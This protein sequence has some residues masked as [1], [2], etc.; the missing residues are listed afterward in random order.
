MIVDSRGMVLVRAA[1]RGGVFGQWK[2]LGSLLLRG[3]VRVAHKF[4]AE[5]ARSQ[6]LS[7]VAALR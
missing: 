4:S 5:L 1:R 6:A 3:D 7:A 2:P